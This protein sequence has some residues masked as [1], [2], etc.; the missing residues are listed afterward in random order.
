MVKQAAQKRAVVV[1]P[2][3]D[4]K[5]MVTEPAERQDR[6]TKTYDTKLMPDT[7]S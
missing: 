6:I 3:N 4:G 1:A 5:F 2:V 7:S